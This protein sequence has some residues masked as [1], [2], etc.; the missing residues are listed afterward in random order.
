[1]NCCVTKG[2]GKNPG[3]KETKTKDDEDKGIHKTHN[4]S[5]ALYLLMTKNSVRRYKGCCTIST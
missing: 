3:R 4:I 5:Y 2:I 1:M